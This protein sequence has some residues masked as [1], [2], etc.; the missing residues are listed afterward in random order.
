MRADLERKNLLTKNINKQLTYSSSG[1]GA[2][3]WH[4]M[5]KGG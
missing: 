2:D 5:V 4:N 3:E 1:Q